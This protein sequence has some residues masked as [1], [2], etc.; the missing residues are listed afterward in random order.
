MVK[1]FDDSKLFLNNVYENI[2]YNDVPL[3]KFMETIYRVINTSINF[4]NF[5]DIGCGRGYFLKFIA[6]K[7]FN[8]IQGIEPS[9]DLSSNK[10][11]EKI[12]SGSFEKN[13]F[14][15]NSFDIVFTC[16]TLHHLEDENPIFAIKEMLRI[17]KKYIVIIEVNNMNIPMFI[18]SLYYRKAEANA[19]RYNLAKVKKMFSLIPC[20]IIKCENLKCGYLSGNSFFH[21]LGALFGT[22]PY[23]IIIAKK[24]N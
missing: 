6:G 18:R 14:E 3:Q 23:N 10:V 4:K 1:D 5:L 16:H 15:D 8:D 20:S 19:F 12:S 2:N 9:N 22:L 21:K 24:N 13:N 17:S 7:G 11:F